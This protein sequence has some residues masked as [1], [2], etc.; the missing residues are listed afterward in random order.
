MLHDVA[1]G[2]GSII[3]QG[4]LGLFGLPRHRLGL[5]ARVGKCPAHCVFPGLS[6]GNLIQI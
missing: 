1:Q 4:E 2:Q 6:D 5:S 3:Y